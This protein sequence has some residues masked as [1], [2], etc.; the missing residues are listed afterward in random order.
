MSLAQYID[1][2]IAEGTS[3]VD[4]TTVVEDH[5]RFER[6]QAFKANAEVL[7]DPWS[8][9]PTVEED[10]LARLREKLTGDYSRKHSC[11]DYDGECQSFAGYHGNLEDEQP[12]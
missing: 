8:S 10:S 12:F 3:D 4:L 1:F 2:L 9:V 6:F 7:F 11:E 5:A